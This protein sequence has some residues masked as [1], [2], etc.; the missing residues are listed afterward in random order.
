MKRLMTMGLLLLGT[1]L[2]NPPAFADRDDSGSFG[3]GPGTMGHGGHHGGGYGMGGGMGM[4]PGMMGGGMG[5]GPLAMHPELAQLPPEKQE[6]LR[7]L[8]SS[9]M[10]AM[11]L[12]RADLQVK[13][14]VLAETM[15]SFPLDQNTAREQRAAVDKS[16][17]EMFELRLSMMAQVQKIVGKELWEQMHSGTPQGMRSQGGGMGPGMA[18]GMMGPGMRGPQQPR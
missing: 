1:L 16:R 17:K 2:L 3:M 6:Q 13:S 15:R 8:H 18:P 5:M 4:G 12:K 10:Q 11:I 9:M 14:L 7:K